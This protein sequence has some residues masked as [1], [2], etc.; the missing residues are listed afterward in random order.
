ME[1]VMLI[2]RSAASARDILHLPFPV[3]LGQSDSHTRADVEQSPTSHAARTRRPTAAAPSALGRS[4]EP[5]LL[6]GSV[7][8]WPTAQRRSAPR[9]GL[10]LPAFGLPNSRRCAGHRS[11]VSTM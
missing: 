9:P 7:P 8:R 1:I 3:T 11:N 4:A 2:V 6:R 5:P 10:G